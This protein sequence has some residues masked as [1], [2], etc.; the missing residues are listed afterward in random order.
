M[1]VF[2]NFAYAPFVTVSPLAT[3]AQ[4]Q[5]EAEIRKMEQLEANAILH[6]NRVGIEK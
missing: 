1:K 6:L 5:K 4:N 2:K 3:L